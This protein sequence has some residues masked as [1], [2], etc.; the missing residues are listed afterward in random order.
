MHAR[1]P[2]LAVRGRWADPRVGGNT[3]V[4]QGMHVRPIL[5]D[6]CAYLIR[7]ADGPVT[8]DEDIDVARHDQRAAAKIEG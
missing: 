8:R 7:S 3:G 1:K 2:I 4:T 6:P 5:V